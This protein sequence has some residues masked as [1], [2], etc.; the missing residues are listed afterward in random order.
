MTNSLNM[1]EFSHYQSGSGGRI[2]VRR[3]GVGLDKKHI[4]KICKLG[5]DEA[6]CSFLSYTPDGFTCLKKTELEEFISQKRAAGE[7][8]AKG[9]NCSGP[10]NFDTRDRG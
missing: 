4:E 1:L 2:S 5:G 9:D 3:K 10:P 7:M 8:R 6:V